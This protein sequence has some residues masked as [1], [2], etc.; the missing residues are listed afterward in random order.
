VINGG[1]G[2]RR[3]SLRSTVLT[4]NVVDPIVFV[5]VEPRLERR[6]IFST[7]ARVEGPVFLGAE[8]LA[9]ALAIDD[10]PERHRLHAPR[11][12]SALD[13]VPQKRAELVADQPVEHPP[14]LVGVEQVAIE[15]RGIGDRL[16]DRGGRDFMQQ[17]AADLGLG[18]AEMVGD[19]PRD[20]LTFAVGV[21]G[22]V[23]IVLALG[24]ALDLTEYLLFALDGDEIGGE[25]VLD[26]DPELA[27]GQ[28]HDVADRGH[29]LVVATEIA[30]DSFR[31]CGRFYDYEIF[32]HRFRRLQSRTQP[33]RFRASQNPRR[34]RAYT[35]PE[36]CK[37]EKLAGMLGDA[38]FEFKFQK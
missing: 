35:L 8:R 3:T 7:E 32:C 14:R 31:L 19:M 20:R 15:L 28:V 27:L 37:R 9:L 10:Y 25:I 11:A 13:L 17:D 4:L 18:F 38:T 21:A 36:L 12:D 2:L 34:Y 30:L 33:R 5:T 22:E 29:H 6:R 1:A 26:I 16:F 23:D 24:G